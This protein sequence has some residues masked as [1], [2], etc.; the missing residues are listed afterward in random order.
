[1][2]I[3]KLPVNFYTEVLFLANIFEAVMPSFENITALISGVSVVILV[4][5][6]YQKFR[7]IVLTDME[8]RE[9][10][11]IKWFSELP[12]IAD[13]LKT[14]LIWI[15]L[16]ALQPSFEMNISNLILLGLLFSLLNNIFWMQMQGAVEAPSR[17]IALLIV[18]GSFQCTVASVLIGMLLKH[19][20]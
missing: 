1:M 16:I 7:Y 5:L 18:V 2:Q 20:F 4:G 17:I 10:L 6:I 11:R 13:I 19:E 14:I 12:L 9:N 8:I 3:N 15:F